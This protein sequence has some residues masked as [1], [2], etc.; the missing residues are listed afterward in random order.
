MTRKQVALV[1][2]FVVLLNAVISAAISV[3]VVLLMSESTE[4]VLGPTPTSTVTTTVVISEALPTEEA[5]THIVRSGDT[6]SG[7]AFEYD[8]PEEYIIAANELENPNFLQVGMELIIPVG[9]FSE[10][11]ATFT[12]APTPTD[13]PIPFEPPSAELTATAA[14]ELGAT[15]TPLPT[16][17]P[18]GGE[19][20]IDISEILGAGQID[21]ER[22]VLASVGERLADMQ[23]W[24]LSDDDGS[25]YTFPNFRLWAG[26]SVTVHTRIGADGSPPANLYWGKLEP[27]WSPGEVVRL[28]DEEGIEISSAIVAP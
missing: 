27:V 25:V 20:Q 3:A 22:V 16:P 4:V 13:T 12:P 15:A 8:V 10:A 14:A 2:A 6:I 21:Q 23:G 11:T 19:L 24:T 7:L 9:G 28:K 18:S 26:G 17:L 5:V 1:A